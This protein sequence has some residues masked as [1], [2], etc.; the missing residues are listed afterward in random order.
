MLF[1]AMPESLT[2]GPRWLVLMLVGILTIPTVITHRTGHTRLNEIVAYACLAVITL[3]VIS[4]I[5]LLVLGL[6]SHRET[7][8][9]LLE[10]ATAL[11]VSNVLLFASWYWRLDGGGPNERDK[12]G[13][14]TDGAFLF[15]QMIMDN[16]L[17]KQMGEEGWSPG[18]I[19]YLFLAF[20][21]ST[22]FSP[23][24]VPVLSRWAKALM[25]TQAVIAL[26]TVVLLAARAVN[27]L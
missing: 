8:I 24:D 25:M 22:A 23:T 5:A 16:E 15:P 14:H 9:Q 3:A 12:R 21:T 6:P 20:N 17:K 18:F 10:A 13:G 11:W 4:S 19:D 7:P 1:Y 26:A 2:V 27:I